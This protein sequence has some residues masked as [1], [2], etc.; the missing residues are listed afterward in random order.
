LF[1]F[2][3]NSLFKLVEIDRIYSEPSLFIIGM[4]YF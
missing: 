4:F 2:S 1:F 3:F